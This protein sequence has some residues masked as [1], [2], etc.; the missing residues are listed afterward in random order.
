MTQTKCRWCK[1]RLTEEN[2]NSLM[3][4]GK[5][6]CFQCEKDVETQSFKNRLGNMVITVAHA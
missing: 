2:H 3:E 6:E 4:Q 5:K 1:V